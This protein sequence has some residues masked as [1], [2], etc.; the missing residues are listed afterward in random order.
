MRLGE[1]LRRRERALRAATCAE[2]YLLAVVQVRGGSV[3][4]C[5]GDHCAAAEISR[6]NYTVKETNGFQMSIKKET[7]K[8]TSKSNGKMTEHLIGAFIY[9]FIHFYLQPES[10]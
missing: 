1:A 8:Q 2:Y 5:L 7:L 10:C 3:V 4:V 9:L 6:R